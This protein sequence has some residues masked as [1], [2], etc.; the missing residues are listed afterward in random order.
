ME[1]MFKSLRIIIILLKNLTKTVDFGWIFNFLE[2][3]TSLISNI[4]NKNCT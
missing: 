4:Y 3:W 1:K 2:I